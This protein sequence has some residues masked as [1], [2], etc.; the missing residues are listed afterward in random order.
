MSLV[1]GPTIILMKIHPQ[2]SQGNPEIQFYHTINKQLVLSYYAGILHSKC[3][4]PIHS[5]DTIEDGQNKNYHLLFSNSSSG[6]FSGEEFH[7][8]E[9]VTSAV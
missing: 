3:W 5:N 2:R 9:L 4:M 6:K 1:R 7:F 8:V